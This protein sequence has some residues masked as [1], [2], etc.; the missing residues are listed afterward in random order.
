MWFQAMNRCPHPGRA[1]QPC[2]RLEEHTGVQ[3]PGAVKPIWARLW[4]PHT[5]MCS[6]PG[7]FT[8]LLSVKG[9]N[10]TRRSNYCQII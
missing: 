3:L 5:K 4:A 2:V 7:D 1:P 10:H 8:D 6:G 9:N